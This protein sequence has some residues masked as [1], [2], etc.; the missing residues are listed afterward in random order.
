MLQCANTDLVA[1]VRHTNLAEVPSLSALAFCITTHICVGR[2]SYSFKL[3]I[4][5]HQSGRHISNLDMM[6]YNKIAY[7][8]VPAFPTFQKFLGST[9]KMKLVNNC[10][11]LGHKKVNCG[12]G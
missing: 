8:L 6:G 9:T 12:C 5:M 7:I 11:L 2:N 3:R 4:E 10:E 1:A